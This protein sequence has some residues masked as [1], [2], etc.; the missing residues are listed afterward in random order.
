MTGDTAR[1]AIRITAIYDYPGK[2]WQKDAI[3]VWGTVETKL[4][5]H[6]PLVGTAIVLWT[7]D[8]MAQDTMRIAQKQHQLVLVDWVE[9]PEGRT[10]LGCE[11]MEESRVA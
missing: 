7:E 2:S 9:R 5:S 10:I 3:E 4:T 1:H 6:R 11:L 8:P